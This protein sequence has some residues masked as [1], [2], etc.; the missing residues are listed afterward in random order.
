[1]K[2]LKKNNIIL[3]LF[4]MSMFSSVFLRPNNRMVCNPQGTKQVNVKIDLDR[5]VVTRILE[6]AREAEAIALGIDLNDDGGEQ[7][8][9]ED[10]DVDEW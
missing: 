8:I 5:D 6:D 2:N 3:S 7:K 9:N 10:D 1:M 4:Y